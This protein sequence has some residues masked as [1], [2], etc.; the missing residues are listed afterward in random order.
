[1][2][3]LTSLLTDERGDYPS[4]TQPPM[5]M[6]P[7]PNNH[8]KADFKLD[9]QYL[10]IPRH[11]PPPSYFTPPPNQPT[12]RLLEIKPPR[13]IAHS[14]HLLDKLDPVK[15]NLISVPSQRVT[16]SLAPS[17]LLAFKPRSEVKLF[18]VPAPPSKPLPLLRLDL[19][20]EPMNPV[21]RPVTIVKKNSAAREKRRVPRYQREPSL[22]ISPEALLEPA[23]EAEEN[24]E[25]LP[26]R[27]HT[28]PTLPIRASITPKVK[29]RSE[30]VPLVAKV[31]IPN[32]WQA[33]DFLP[34]NNNT[35]GFHDK[36]EPK[37]P[38][39]SKKYEWYGDA[40]TKNAIETGKENR[41]DERLAWNQ[42]YGD[43]IVKVFDKLDQSGWVRDKL[44]NQIDHSRKVAL[45]SI[46]K[47]T[48]IL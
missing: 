48:V 21:R 23:P 25:P 41:K 4:H 1:M 24:I 47:N 39:I 3:L 38:V 34:G 2:H 31:A 33:K 13:I 22:E 5:L 12:E 42:E 28:T 14:G 32:S 8:P 37:R 35:K 40:V 29:P 27:A 45:T 20:R 18:R 19:V 11:L 30:R 15:A 16:L 44:V 10:Q 26:I 43:L 46:M 9:P 7:P 6:L 36:E 17:T